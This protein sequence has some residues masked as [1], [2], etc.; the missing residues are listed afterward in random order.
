MDKIEIVPIKEALSAR[1]TVKK[2]KEVAE[3][4]ETINALSPGQSGKIVA[5]TE[6]PQTVKNRVWRVI[7]ALGMED[8]VT[9]KRTGDTIYFFKVKEK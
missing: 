2:S 9:V 8:E 5:K 6:K 1:R 4:E 7:K 3:I